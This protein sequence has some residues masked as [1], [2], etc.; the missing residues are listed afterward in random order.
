MIRRARNGVG[1]LNRILTLGL[2]LLLLP[3][4]DLFLL[5]VLGRRW[6]QKFSAENFAKAVIAQNPKV[7]ERLAE[8]YGTSLL[9]FS[10]S[11]V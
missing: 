11:I 7:F 10:S 9:V 2:V 8:M 5:A 6:N 3:E 4:I 1:L